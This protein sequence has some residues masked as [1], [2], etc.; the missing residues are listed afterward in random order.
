MQ[1]FALCLLCGNVFDILDKHL[2]L[3]MYMFSHSLV[4]N[5]YEMITTSC[6]GKRADLTCWQCKIIFTQKIESILMTF[7]FVCLGLLSVSAKV[8]PF[9]RRVPILCNNM[10][11]GRGF[12]KPHSFREKTAFASIMSYRWLRMPKICLR[13]LKLLVVGTC[14]RHVQIA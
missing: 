6:A 13:R 10:T 1:F 3:E 2:P 9:R 12:R 7:Y 11:P 8:R 4:L 5:V 14:F